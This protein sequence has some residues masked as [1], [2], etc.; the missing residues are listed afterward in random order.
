MANPWNFIKSWTVK[1]FNDTHEPNY[2][3]STDIL[4]TKRGLDTCFV[5]PN[6]GR[7]PSVDSSNHLDVVQHAHPEGGFFNMSVPIAATTDIILLDLSDTTNYPHINTGSIHMAW[8]LFSIEASSNADYELSLGFLNNVDATDG[9]YWEIFAVS[10][11][12]QTGV[13]KF[14][15]LSVAPD[16][17]WCKPDRVITNNILLNQT[18]FQTDVNM[19]TILDPLTADTPPGTGDIVVRITINAGDIVLDLSGNYHSHS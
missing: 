18:A 14:Q 11:T 3:T 5:D 4:T 7:S 15:L 17:P 6:S 10:G 2:I 12:K 19:K 8:M 9:D 1:H 16:G 13:N